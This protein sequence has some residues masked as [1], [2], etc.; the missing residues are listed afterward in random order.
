MIIVKGE[1]PVKTDH[2]DEAVELVQALAEASRSEDG[3]L[4]YEV[5]LQADRP[6][7]IVVWQ[8]WRSL[9]ALESHFASD[10]V[11]AFLDAIPDMIDGQ[12]TSARYEVQ[13]GDDEPL[14]EEMLDT[15]AVLFG[16]E[17]VMH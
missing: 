6:E 3:C 17:V 2:R 16:E 7:V 9:E 11:D 13:A 1:I 12:V 14:A 15:A 10:H 8:Q 4:C 5:Y